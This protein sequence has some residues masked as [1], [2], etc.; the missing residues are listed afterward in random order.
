MP[1]SND[2]ISQFVKSTRDNTK[3]KSETTVYGT[4]QA[5]DG[6]HKD[7]STVY[8]QL[9]NTDENLYTPVKA[10]SVYIDPKNITVG[11]RVMVLIKNHTATI[12]GSLSHPSAKKEDLD[13]T[14]KTLDDKIVNFDTIIA[15]KA[16]I[17]DLEAATA[18]IGDLETDNLVVKETLTANS[19]K[20][21][22]LETNKLDANIAEITYA[23]ITELNAAKG[24]ISILNSDVADINALIFGSAT[25]STIQTSFANAVIAQLGNAQI[26]S[27]MI[28]SVS[29]SK[30]TSGDIVTNNVK[31]KSQN[32]LLL[33]SDETIQI[34]DN[35]RVRV[36]IGKDASNDYSI[37][38]WDA[39]G[40]LMFSK[41]GIT[42]SAIKDAI[43]RND[44]V[45]DT[46]NIAAHKLDIDSLFDEINGS[47]N[48]IKSTKVYLDDKK[49]TL[50]VAF[51][52]ITTDVTDL[53]ETVSSQGTQISAVQ[54][55][56][57]SKIWQQDINIAKNELGEQTETLSTQQSSLEQNLNSFKSTVSS[58]YATKSA[59]NTTNSNVTALGTR[60]TNAETSITQISNKIT[61]NVTETTN[62]GT[63]VSTVEQTATGLTTRLDNQ[64][65]GGTN[66]LRG[67][68]TVTT[69]GSSS[70]WANST[71]RSAGGGTGSRSI[72]NISDAPN[73]DIKKGIQIVGDDTDTTTAQDNIPVTEGATYTISCY[74][75]GTGSMRLQVG[76]SPYSAIIHTLDNVTK[77]TKYS[78]TFVAG[79]GNGVTDGK[80]NVYFG[81]RGTGT[82]QMCGF[83]MELGT[84]ATDWT[85]SPYDTTS[86]IEAASKTATNYLGF[87]S[88]GLVVGDMTASTLGNNVLI[89][90]DS[91]DIR[92]NTTT[93]ASF[94]ANYLYLA[95]NSRNAT[96]DLC[97]GLAKLYHQSRL[98][99]D[100]LFV[101]E[102]PNA[103]EIRGTSDPLCVTSTVTSKPAIKFANS[104]GVL[105]SIGMV[106]SGT[107]SYITRNH[108]STAAT[109]SILDTGNFYKLMD[110]GW[111][112]CSLNTGS[113]TRYNND[114]PQPQVRKIG[115]QVYLRGEAKP[116][117][118]VT[119]E[120]DSDTVI[121]TIPSGYRPAQRKQFIMQG[122][123]SYRWL[124]SI[125][126]D[127]RIAV[128][129]YSNTTTANMNIAA[130]AW[131][132]CHAQWLID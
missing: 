117:V 118:A 102:T 81:N 93:L 114:I 82:L 116:V 3:T 36:Q 52:S 106:A 9:D 16:D 104:D 65:I 95:K 39:S 73:G 80:T 110:S 87:S 6:E 59:L 92:K 35:T 86:G 75:K 4:V 41:G 12:T 115:K 113:F 57:T 71:W 66:I 96:I 76:R 54:G 24:D 23:T 15:K 50:D 29:A 42:D 72:I 85:P 47:T 131:L 11:E 60:I 69:L 89:D 61:A 124:M 100:T 40:N 74:A 5:Y 94:G 70:S 49:Q 33:I 10:S 38:I 18:R 21:L 108:P 119:P 56:I 46:A 58:T 55:Q 13:N 20:I 44:M 105:G 22:K 30:I 101:I 28:D 43:I 122:S 99:Y 90:S 111:I 48:T 84:V 128:S 64:T 109:Y 83:K 91:V 88:G 78:I 77:W 68:N 25:G 130:G 26:K 129:R 62:L 126:T 121:A 2:L 14:S 132:C 31:V 125:H 127:G 51:K 8:V 79:D 27:A 45:S 63:R 97:N 98:S 37:N 107:E 103:T 120:S 123:G 17:K 67:T 112:N 19:A 32:G 7:D 34:K 53:S 1:L